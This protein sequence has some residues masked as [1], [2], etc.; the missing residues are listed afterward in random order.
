[1]RPTYLIVHC[2]A[3]GWGT[4]LEI[5]GWH[6]A[7]GWR[8]IG[9]HGVVLNGYLT[10]DDMLYDRRIPWLDGS[11]QVG[12][13]WDGD[14]FIEGTE[15]GSHAYGLNSESFSVCLIGQRGTFTP[16][17]LEGLVE[18]CQWACGHFR[19][20]PEHVIGHYE[21]GKFRPEF[22]TDKTCP[23]LDM[24]KIRTALEDGRARRDL[25][26]GAWSAWYARQKR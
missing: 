5:D 9:Y 26:E 19:I 7:R 16:K 14:G 24:E 11:Y 6:R 23:D 10:G 21:I 8:C 13:T 1:M 22:A 4:A 17:Q 25:L 20:A 12:R 15:V 18:H 2:S 3:S